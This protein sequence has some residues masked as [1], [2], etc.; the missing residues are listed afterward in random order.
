MQYVD[1]I[2]IILCISSL[3]F[4]SDYSVEGLGLLDYSNSVMCVIVGLPRAAYCGMQE[5]EAY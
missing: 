2:Y 3:E 5:F 4:N 1:R